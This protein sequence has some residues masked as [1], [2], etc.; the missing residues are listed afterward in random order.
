MI[1]RRGVI[2]L[3]L[4]FSF[5]SGIL[6][7]AQKVGEIEK[8]EREIEKERLLRE[9]IEKEKEE[10]VIEEPVPEVV[11]PAPAE[12]IF[13][14]KINVKGATL[15]SQKEIEEI[16]LPFENKELTLRQMQKVVNLITD[17]YRRQGYVTSRAYLPPQKIK[18]SI[19]EIRV[20][21]GIT[22]EID[23]KGNRYFRTSLL[24]KKITLKKGEVF[25]YNI[26]RED[27]RRINEHPDRRCRAVLMAGKEPGTTDIILEVKD[28]F[29]VH[30]GF[31]WDNFGSRYIEKDRYRLTLTHNNLL[32]L[33]DILTVQYQLAEADTYRLYSLRY[34]FSLQK[35]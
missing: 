9:K 12:K 35:I 7:F 15:L 16:I 4:A 29:P 1:P 32:G 13:I 21:E 20:I 23:I 27:L 8:I 26:L 3:L 19:L 10:P 24:E 6:V 31:E 5:T 18:E 22:G 14:K 30:I 11:P 25:N 17:A 2:F 28:R 33:D 34:L